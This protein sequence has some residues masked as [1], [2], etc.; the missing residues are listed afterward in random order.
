MVHLLM[1]E[2]KILVEFSSFF[3]P[4]CVF[5]G[6][7]PGLHGQGPHLLNH[8]IGLTSSEKI[9]DFNKFGGSHL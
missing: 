6:S 2:E 8:L 5:Q 1:S 9:A 3:L 7:N 4:L